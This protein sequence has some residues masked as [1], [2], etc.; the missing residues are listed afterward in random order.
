MNVTKVHKKLLK[1]YSRPIVHMRNQ[2]RHKRF[3]L[4]FGAGISKRFNLPDWLELVE[5]IAADSEVRG[6]TILKTF[7]DRAS[8][9]YKTELLFQHFRKRQAKKSNGGK[10]H[11]LEFENKILGRWLEI[12]AEHLYKNSNFSMSILRKHPYLL[13]LIPIIQD[14]QLTVTYN[15]DDFLERALQERKS[16]KDVKTRGFE[17]VTNPW[18]QFK[19]PFG[20]VYHPNGI[21][22]S[23][24]ME[25]PRD[26]FI[27]SESSYTKHQFGTKASDSSFLANHLCK[28]TCLIIG[29]SLEDETLRSIFAQSA[30]IAPGNCHYHV[31]FLAKNKKMR[32]ED[33]DAIRRANFN[34]FNIITLFLNEAEIASLAHLIN[35]NIIDDRALN[36][37]SMQLDI[38]LK[39]RFYLTGALGVGKST[40]AN[41]LRNLSVVDEWLEPRPQL[42]AKPWDA[43]SKQ[44]KNKVDKWLANQFRLKDERLR[45]DESGIFVID[46]PPLDPLAFTPT[47]ARPRKAKLLLKTICPQEK[48]EIAEG[49]VIFL[50]GE[51]RELSIRILATGRYDYTPDRLKEMQE[52][53]AEIYKDGEVITL[54]THGM[55]I[56]EATKQV[57]L[58]I[59]FSEYKPCSLSTWVMSKVI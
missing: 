54:D 53:L 1:T 39:Y 21:I 19:R 57:A 24:L 27:F 9:P 50:K 52:D 14:T 22:P 46:R 29:S 48:W 26:R 45:H 33:A 40:I 42:L 11:S 55:S 56:A 34:V 43:L 18:M 30:E 8:L 41:Q 44:E 3:G 28:N 35:P 37:L 10:I 59:H 7:T 23:T 25:L 47:K 17:T 5:R 31:H 4:I 58:L 49:S 38:P 6:K 13:D 12:C 16:E 32:D 51:P 36:D 15:F 20:V 2:L